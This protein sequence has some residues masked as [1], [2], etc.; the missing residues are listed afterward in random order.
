MSG[1]V[2]SSVT[3]KLLSDKDYDLSAIFMKNWDTRDESGTDQGCE[4]EKDWEDVQRVCRKLDMPCK[5]VDLSRQYWNR[6]FAPCLQMWEQGQTPNPD[7]WC[8]KEVKFGALMDQLANGD[9][10]LATGHY[11]DKAWITPHFEGL[12]PSVG[13]SALRPTLIRPKDRAKDQ[14]YYLSAIPEESLARALFPLAPYT[15]SEVR[16]LAQKADLPTAARPESQGICFVGQKRR[17]DKW[18]SEYIPPSPGPFVSLETGETIGHHEGLWHF[19]MCQ[20]ARIRGLAKKAYVAR[21]DLERNII[22]VVPGADHPALY[23]KGLV[24][25]KFQW[26]WRDSPPSSIDTDSGFRCRVQY[27]YRTPDVACTVRRWVTS[28]DPQTDDL[29]VEFDEPR[30]DIAPGQ[31]AVVLDGERVLGCGTIMESF[32]AYDTTYPIHT[33]DLHVRLSLEPRGSLRSGSVR[34]E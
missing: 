7:V 19:T 3:A 16:E 29:R 23:S 1:G 25:T 21:K 28:L 9:C 12:E 30:K 2:D 20:K 31:I 32:D 24:A 10:W 6:V 8:N 5:M 11:A 4:W 14:T 17:F 18:L 22:Y 15:K 26:I 34:P 33:S 13:N 27:G